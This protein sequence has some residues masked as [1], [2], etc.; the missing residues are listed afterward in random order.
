MK[1]VEINGAGKGYSFSPKKHPSEGKMLYPEMFRDDENPTLEFTSSP[2]RE[3]D[4]ADSYELAR[5]SSSF[6][7]DY[8]AVGDS[9]IGFY[10]SPNEGMYYAYYYSNRLKKIISG[11]KFMVN[12]GFPYIK[13]IGFYDLTDSYN[14]P[15]YFITTKKETLDLGHHDP[16]VG[17]E[18][19]RSLSKIMNAAYKK[20]SDQSALLG[21]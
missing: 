4:L 17:T 20:F 3:P 2:I 1:K 5:E 16:R 8:E 18:I 14:N 19:K 9:Q 21:N 7:F 12:N 15:D 10:K 13:I 11:M 6:E